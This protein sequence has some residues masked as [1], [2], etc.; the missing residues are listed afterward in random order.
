VIITEAEKRSFAIM[1]SE[2]VRKE[3]LAVG[4]AAF[5]DDFAT[6][7]ATRS[8]RVD[9]IHGVYAHSLPLAGMTVRQARAELEDRMNIAPEAVAVVDGVEADEAFVLTQ[10][11]V[12]NFVTAA[13]EKGC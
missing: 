3:K 12:L 5:S 13:G 9:V 10:G 2:K 11:Q 8:G 7:T 4:P 1:A 6:G